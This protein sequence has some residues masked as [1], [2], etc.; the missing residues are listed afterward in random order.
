MTSA[1]FSADNLK[2]AGQPSKEITV[3]SPL[4]EKLEE[5]I[6]REKI[7]IAAEVRVIWDSCSSWDDL[8][9]FRYFNLIKPDS[10]VIETF[11]SI[12][13]KEPKILNNEENI[14]KIN[15]F[16]D[17]WLIVSKKI[18]ESFK[19]N[20]YEKFVEYLESTERNIFGRIDPS[21]TIEELKVRSHLK[22]TDESYE[23]FLRREGYNEKQIRELVQI[24]KTNDYVFNR[25]K[26]EEPTQDKIE[27]IIKY[28]DSDERKRIRKIFF[29]VLQ[30]YK[31]FNVKSSK[32]FNF[33]ILKYVK[34]HKKIL[35]PTAIALS[36]LG[37]ATVFFWSC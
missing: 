10:H 22:E 27:Y 6:R 15:D 21:K 32:K 13:Q 17:E 37:V 34:E 23:E 31:L 36:I 35:V 12:I 9:I 8:D 1:I 14:N 25:L 7:F 11:Y 29:Q 28:I 16:V 20:H 33:E 4:K 26:K 3:N 18:W 2:A 5:S 24:K 30:K 19:E